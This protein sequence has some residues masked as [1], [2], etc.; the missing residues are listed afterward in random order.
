MTHRLKSFYTTNIVPELQTQFNYTSGYGLP[1]I[2]K[3]VLNRGLADGQG[4]KLLAQSRD[5]L[6]L[7]TGQRGVI[8]R[9]KK[10]IAAFKLREDMP[11]GVMVTLR[12]EKMYAF[13][14]RLIH[15]ALPRMRD[16]QG[17]SVRSFDE[18]GNYH[19][20]FS[21]QLMFPELSYADVDQQRGLD[22]AIVTTPCS[23]EESFALLQKFGMPFEASSLPANMC[24]LSSSQKV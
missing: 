3:I 1:R 23:R 9:S 17:V 11:I 12:D 16:F 2:T 18:Q 22:I 14:D 19:L 15:L 4:E 21:D 10:A 20:G 7:I 8:T 6:T 5:E 13:L 24:Q